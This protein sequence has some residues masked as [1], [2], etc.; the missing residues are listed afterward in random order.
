MFDLFLQ[1]LA[2]TPRENPNPVQE[3]EIEL[4]P[5]TNR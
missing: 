5:Q 1:D 3:P 2:I 4:F